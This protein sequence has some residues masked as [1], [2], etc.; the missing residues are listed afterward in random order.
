[1][2]EAVRG[3]CAP[4]RPRRWPR[5]CG[6][7]AAHATRRP[8]PASPRA[9]GC[10]G[11]TAA[12]SALGG[13]RVALR[14]EDHAGSCPASRDRGDTRDGHG[15]LQ[16]NRGGAGGGHCPAAICS[17]PNWY[18]ARLAILRRACTDQAASALAGISG[19]RAAR[20]RGPSRGPRLRVEPPCPSRASCAGSGP[21]RASPRPAP[22]P[23]RLRRAADARYL[24]TGSR[25]PSVRRSESPM[26]DAS[27]ESAHSEWE[28]L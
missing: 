13:V 7:R 16:A 27:K 17:G 15:D 25:L 21:G 4:R 9:C 26:S 19:V 14:H 1:M 20:G 24:R 6:R 3:G 18:G 23:R 28:G 5:L 10:G 22:C 8:P 11:R 2:T 12:A